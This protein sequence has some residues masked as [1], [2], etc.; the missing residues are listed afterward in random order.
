MNQSANKDKKPLTVCYLFKVIDGKIKSDIVAFATDDR[1][2]IMQTIRQNWPDVQ[3]I[4]Y[5]AH[6]VSVILAI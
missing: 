1:T 3:Q 5:D 4:V 6:E 2:D